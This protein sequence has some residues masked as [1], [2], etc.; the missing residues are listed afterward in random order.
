[1]GK[2]K[3]VNVN[4]QIETEIRDKDGKLIKKSRQEAHS[5][6]K[7]FAC[8]LY[9]LLGATSVTRNNT[10]GSSAT[11]YG[12]F[13]VTSA[14]T[15]H[16]LSCAAPS[17]DDSF[18]IQVGTSDTAVTRDD[19]KLGSKISHGSGSGQLAYGSM[20]VEAVD[21]TPPASRFR[22][23]RVFSNNTT[24]TIT[25]KEIGLAI[26]NVWMSLNQAFLIARDV[27]TSPQD[28]PSGATLTVRYIFEV[29]A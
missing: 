11:F 10:S 4:V 20:T 15:E 8:F 1:M 26:R 28:V 24:E 17:G 18:G 16:P 9:A 5:L 14:G 12:S 23:I 2:G 21:G 13:T 29:T 6:L 3:N 22:V 19:Y 25:V 7:N 27:L